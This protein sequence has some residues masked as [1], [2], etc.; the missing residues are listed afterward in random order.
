MPWK[1]VP[2]DG[3]ALD[4]ELAQRRPQNGGRRLAPR[5]HSGRHPR[6]IMCDPGNVAGNQQP[7]AG[8]WNPADATALIAWRLTNQ[9]VRCAHV[10][11]GRQPLT[12]RAWSVSAVVIFIAI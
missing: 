1:R 5:P 12:A 9:Q 7:L 10:Q 6:T 2:K 11:M 8:E 3:G 4:T